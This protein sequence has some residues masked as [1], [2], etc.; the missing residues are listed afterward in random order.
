MAIK[1][2]NNEFIQKVFSWMFLG[3]LVSAVA[4]YASITVPS[5]NAL[6][7]LSWFFWA[8][9]ITE[10]ILVIVLSLA[11]KRM[12]PQ[13]ATGMFLLY[14]LMSGLTISVIVMA[15]ELGTVA[16]AFVTAAGMFGAMAAYGYYTKSDLSTLGMVCL[17]ALFG[18]IIASVI[19]IFVQSSGMSLILNYLAVI[20]FAGLTAYDLHQMK[21]VEFEGSRKKREENKHR[22]AIIFALA[23]Y[24]NLI[25][26]FLSLLQ[27]FGG[28]DN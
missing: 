21:N 13:V 16:L 4:A 17:M 23:L 18:L 10:V 24:L 27:I 11:I 26:M 7:T 8:V 12:T 20:I 6:V 15:Y 19:N 22:A 28:N 3:L 25:N 14:S 1:N 5:L 2:Q 9:L